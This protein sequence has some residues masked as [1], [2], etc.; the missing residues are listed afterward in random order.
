MNFKILNNINLDMDSPVGED[1]TDA[2]FGTDS[3]SIL[4]TEVSNELDVLWAEW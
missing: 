4:G 2:N 1:A 3:E